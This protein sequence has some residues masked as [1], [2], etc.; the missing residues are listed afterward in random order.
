MTR[1]FTILILSVL[2]SGFYAN[3]SAQC[4]S[5]YPHSQNF[6]NF[7]SLQ[8]T[9]SC[10]AGVKG[11]SANGWYQD[12]NDGGE[13]R[14]D[15]A[16]TASVGTGPGATTTTSGVGSGT[17]YVPGTTKGI[18]LYT[19]ATSSTGCANA[20]VNLLSPCFDFSD[21]GTYYRMKFAYHM[22]GGGMGSLS[23]DVY[24]G[25]KWVTDVWTRKGNQGTSWLLATVNLA[26]FNGSSVQLRIRAV[27]G[28]TYQS[29]CAIDA[30]TV[31]TY[32]PPDYDAVLTEVSKGQS[33]Y[34]F[35]PVKHT[36]SMTF[37]GKM[38]NDGLKSI[39]GVQLKYQANGGQDS[40]SI[41]TVTALSKDSATFSTSYTPTGVADSIIAFNVTLNE[42]DVDYNNNRLSLRTNITQT[43]YSRD[44]GSWSGGIGYNAGSGQIGNMFELRTA[45]TLSSVT[46]FL[47]G[48]ASGD[49]MRVHLYNYSGTTPGGLIATSRTTVASGNP[50]WKT[51]RFSCEP[52]LNSG[53]YFI[54]VEQMVSG[55]NM[56]LGYSFDCYTQNTSFYGNGSTWTELGAGGFS[57]CLLVRLNLDKPQRPTVTISAADTLCQGVVSVA[58]GSGATTY[59]WSPTGIVKTPTAFNTNFSADS[60]FV[61]RLKGTNACGYVGL[62]EH[63]VVIKKNPSAKVSNDTTVCKNRPVVLK[64]NTNN[65][66]QWSGGPMN[67]NYT[68]SPAASTTY[69]VQIDS[70]NGCKKLFN[71]QVNV[72]I[73]DAKANNDT[74]VCEAQPIQLM[75]SGGT[76]Y[77]WQNG[78]ATAGYLVMPRTNQQYVVTVKDAL[79]CQ[80]NDTVNVG[81]NPGPPLK[82]SNDTSLCFGQR[83][84]MKASGATSYQWIGGP[85]TATYNTI[86][87]VTRTYF[88]K[89]SGSDG[90]FLIDSVQVTV[91]SIPK[92]NV[93]ADTTICEGI[94]LDLNADTKDQV[95]FIWSNGDTAQ[96][97]KVTPQIKTKYKVV[98]ANTTGCTAEDSTTITVNPLPRVKVSYSLVKRDVTFSNTSQNSNTYAWDFGDGTTGTAKNEFHKYDVD[99][100]YTV[101]LTVTNNC[102]KDDT[103][104]TIKIENLGVDDL[105]FNRLSIHPNP[106][107]GKSALSLLSDEFGPINM[108]VYDL[109]G[110]L[111]KSWQEVKSEQE[112]KSEIDLSSEADGVYLIHLQSSG[113]VTTRQLIISR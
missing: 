109:K 108:S 31:E 87:I 33:E 79:G 60:T 57:A 92:V 81:I 32:S 23:V 24:D 3:L 86:P 63:R 65:N 27:M 5:R 68:V 48:P 111:I 66:Y 30:I 100:S 94:S 15:T 22:F 7:D 99:G 35:V 45:D 56:S 106:A 6:E 21:T 93:R 58:K 80:S 75:A 88:V 72:S 41:G 77:Q 84:I 44:K 18:Y 25:S 43:L 37:S 2:G 83:L 40:V 51:V 97:I 95:N 90:C 28:P 107:T 102:G 105:D 71:I 82:T 85:A 104:F 55:S 19:E 47:N 52:I 78:P 16:G 50:E 17:D 89:G 42:T 101:K 67:A 14:A 11:D 29:D 74:T 39:T 53:K 113:G 110:R 4:V 98:V 91:A 36:R 38:K 49:S 61:L 1:N 46:F 26:Q 9:E 10:D 112:L 12:L 13:W 34:Y 103:T 62:A 76:S 59:Q 8:T 69:S 20:V 96:N 70:S 64:A 73:P 54:A